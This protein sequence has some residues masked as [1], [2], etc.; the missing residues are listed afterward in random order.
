MNE[1]YFKYANLEFEKLIL[2]NKYWLVLTFIASLPTLA[3][4]DRYGICE[5][6]NCGGGPINGIFGI[7][8]ILF[9]L[10]F[11]GFKKAG[12]YLAVWLLPV[13]IAILMNE[14]LIGALW[15]VFGFYLSFFITAWIIE[16]IEK[17]KKPEKN[18]II[19]EMPREIVNERPIQSITPD[20]EK[21]C[22]MITIRQ[23]NGGPY[24]VRAFPAEEVIRKLRKINI[25]ESN[26]SKIADIINSMDDYKFNLIDELVDSG[27]DLVAESIDASRVRAIRA[28]RA[29]AKEKGWSI[30]LSE[31]DTVTKV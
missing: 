12:I 10:S 16:F 26:I 3:M 1:Y 30:V 25:N 18:Q 27:V 5:E 7:I 31:F 4:A 6:S 13:L 14:K 11:L 20:I 28:T 19:K 2:K 21:Y 22:F 8:L 29:N 24:W 17:D 23:W 9:F 15:G